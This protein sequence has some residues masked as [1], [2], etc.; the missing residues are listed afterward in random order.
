ME[1]CGWYYGFGRCTGLG[2]VLVQCQVFLS[3]DAEEFKMSVNIYQ[4]C[5][6]NLGCANQRR[7]LLK[8]TNITYTCS[9]VKVNLT[10][11]KVTHKLLFCSYRLI[12]L[13]H[14]SGC[15]WR[16]QRNGLPR[17]YS[18]RWHSIYSWHMCSSPTQCS[19][20]YSNYIN[21]YS[22]TPHNTSQREI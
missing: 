1:I 19:T 10:H 14:M 3:F 6:E 7:F 21:K 22:C 13:F 20:H 4:D 16:H 15:I 12:C 11:R 8:T 17:W 18:H 9:K 2:G 5:R